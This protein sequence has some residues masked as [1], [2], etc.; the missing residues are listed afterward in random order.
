[1]AKPLI[2]LGSGGHAHVLADLIAALGRE[3]T[4]CVG[5][6]AAPD[7][8][9]APGLRYLGDETSLAG[10]PPDTVEL[11]NGVG[12]VGIA[13][14]RAALFQRWKEAG[15]GFATL[16]HPAAVVARHVVLGEG[17][18]VMAG[19]VIQTRCTIGANVIVNTRAS[20]DH[21]CRIGDHVHI[22]P[23]ATLSGEVVVGQSVHIGA[24]SVI[25][26]GV[27]IGDGAVVGAGAAVLR[28]VPGQV[29]VTGVP[30]RV[31]R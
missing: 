16:V 3:L 14:P 5:L 8:P 11:V 20:V 31:R 17:T 24:G 29:T 1:M 18:V 7:A 22:A 23:G 13:G 4:G 27:R 30:A 21:D 28:D 12:S 10:F 2:L 6:T 25:I 19:A 9:L 26:Q 15:Y